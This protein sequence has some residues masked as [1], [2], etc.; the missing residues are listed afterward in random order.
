MHTSSNTCQVAGRRVYIPMKHG[1]LSL[2]YEGHSTNGSN[3]WKTMYASPRSGRCSNVS[4]NEHAPLPC[5]G[6]VGVNETAGRV[7]NL[8]LHHFHYYSHHY[9]QL[10]A[11]R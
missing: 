7:K 11:H 9:T 6:P 2:L 1:C 5:H 3:G 10:L 8:T 4:S